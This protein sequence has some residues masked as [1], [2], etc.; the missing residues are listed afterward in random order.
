MKEQREKNMRRYQKRKA[1]VKIK[2]SL[3][4]KQLE[5]KERG[6]SKLMSTGS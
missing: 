4:K 6:I 1:N 5:N 3:E 2:K